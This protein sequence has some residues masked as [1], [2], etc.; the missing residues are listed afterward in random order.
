MDTYHFNTMNDTREIYYY[1]ESKG[2]YVGGGEIIIET[3]AESMT[4][5]KITTGIVNEVMNHI[6]RRTYTNRAEFDSCKPEILNL[7]NGLLNVDTLQ[8][9]EHSSEHLSLVQ[10]PIRYDSKAK[11]PNILKFLGEVLHPQDIFTAMQII[12]YCLYKSAEYEKAVM[13]VGPGANGKGVFIKII[14][15]LVGLENTSHVTLQDLDNDRFAQL[16]CTAKW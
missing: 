6:R 7:Q 3:L 12:G 2:I 4:D 14:E 8:F 13:L 10:S 1:D 5:G 11:C 9:E 15:A 16:D